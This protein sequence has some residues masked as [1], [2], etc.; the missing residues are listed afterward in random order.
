MRL[1]ATYFRPASTVTPPIIERVPIITAFGNAPFSS[2]RPFFFSSFARNGIL[3]K[4]RGRRSCFPARTA[5]DAI[6]TIVRRRVIEKRARFPLRFEHKI[7][8]PMRITGRMRAEMA[9]C[10]VRHNFNL[11]S[12]RVTLYDAA[13]HA[14]Q[15]IS[16]VSSRTRVV[17]FLFGHHVQTNSIIPFSKC[18]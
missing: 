2:V 12:G 14:C 15:T 3:E 11:F 13:C 4:S 9:G 17:T 1:N 8:R 7:F 5:R 10:R 18:P 6:R 16:Q